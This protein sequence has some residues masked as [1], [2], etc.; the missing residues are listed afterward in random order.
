MEDTHAVHALPRGGLVLC[1]ADGHGSRLVSE[2]VYLGGRECADAACTC[3]A[4]NATK[5]T[6]QKL[7]AACQE[8]CEAE[9]ERVTPG[10]PLCGTTLSVA[11]LRP[12]RPSVFAWAGDSL[13]VLVRRGGDIV[14]LGVAHGRANR[15][16]FVRMRAAGA[17]VDDKHFQ[18]KVRGST[19][20]LA[21]S[22]SL[23]HAEQPG[24]LHVP[25]VETFVPEPGDRIVV[26]TDGL[27]DVC[28]W[29]RAGR[30]VMDAPTEDAACDALLR[31][32]L[33]NPHPRDN[34]TVVCHFVEVPVQVC[35]TVS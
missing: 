30:V 31:I 3:A 7:F 4:A 28:T 35:C 9:I 15:D 5:M 33:N 14:P 26:A 19:V 34:V 21:L 6:A 1:V 24:V 16:E 25:D 12:N 32:A 8:A 23:G 13:G 18:Y 29:E 20:R 27:W 17:K 2:G 22:R 11:V 10:N